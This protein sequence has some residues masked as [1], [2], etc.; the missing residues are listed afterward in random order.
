M[1]KDQSE[2]IF[3]LSDRPPVAEAI[4]AALQHLLAIVVSIM[5]PALIICGAIGLG[6]KDTSYIVSM[7][8]MVSGIATFIQVKKIGPIGSGI[9][10]IQG[11]SF[12]FIGVMISV[13][14]AETAKSGDPLKALPML[15][16]L[17]FV[18]SFIE[19]VCSRFIKPLRKLIT[20]LVSGIVVCLIGMTL[21]GSAMQNCAGGKLVLAGLVKGDVPAEAVLQN[22]LLSFGVVGLIL[23]LN[24]SSNRW[25]R[26]GS[27]FVG[28]VAGYIVS[29]F[30]GIIDFS[31]LKGLELFNIPVPFKYGFAF[32][33]SAFV[34]VALLY[35]V[36]LVETIGDITATSIVSSEPI[37]GDLYVERVS[38]GVFGDGFNSMLAAVFNTFPNTTFSQNNGIIQLT[39]VASRYVG[40]YVAGFL[41]VLGLFPYLSTLAALMPAP[42]LGGAT[43]LMFGTV[44]SSGIRIIAAQTMDRRGL[45]VLAI[46]LGTGLGV[47]MVPEILKAFP[48][49]F[50]SIFSSGIITGGLTA[51]FANFLIPGPL[52]EEYLK[53][54]TELSPKVDFE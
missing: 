42:I 41:V 47:T 17:C 12:A 3:G 35:V 26:M 8:L 6:M 2:I 23:L 46:S 43:L 34:G 32:S 31:T 50:S 53:E 19:M 16:G 49:W 38:G 20:P 39:G 29:A 30:L 45:L 52:K 54:E 7:S 51:I 21:I 37:E 15:F 48:E 28:L 18:G 22:L 25:I 1:E 44:A 13:G 5:T 10:S 36:T 11:T 14:L 27:I 33:P 4:F 9:L 24:S 40:F